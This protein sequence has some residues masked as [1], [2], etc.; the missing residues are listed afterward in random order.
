M[1]G[2][3]NTSSQFRVEAV[4]LA[5][6]WISVFDNAVVVICGWL[7]EVQAMVCGGSFVVVGDCYGGVVLG[8]DLCVV[9]G[10]GDGDGC[11]VVVGGDCGGG[12][13]GADMWLVVI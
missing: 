6:I 1:P 11:F 8:A 13:M 2:S 12:V 10:A 3:S 5:H 4:G 9:G 7:Y